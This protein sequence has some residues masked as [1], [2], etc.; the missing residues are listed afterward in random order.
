MIFSGEFGTSFIGSWVSE[1]AIVCYGIHVEEALR[2]ARDP[3]YPLV[4]EAIR[5]GLLVDGAVPESKHPFCFKVYSD[6]GISAVPNGPNG[7][8]RDIFILDE[9]LEGPTGVPGLLTFKSF[10]LR[11][12]DLELKS[13][14]YHSYA[15]LDIEVTPSGEIAVP[16]PVILH[17]YFVKH[18]CEVDEVKFDTIAAFR[19]THESVQRLFNTINPSV[20]PETLVAK[21]VGSMYDTQGTNTASLKVMRQELEYIRASFWTPT[22]DPIA[23]YTRELYNS[24]PEDLKNKE[25]LSDAV[26]ILKKT[27]HVSY[28]W[29]DFMI[30]SNDHLRLKYLRQGPPRP[31]RV[32][33][34]LSWSDLVLRNEH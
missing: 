32:R 21:V 5:G 10:M 7:A 26:D 2:A 14:S 6:D 33:S 25:W 3:R 9:K 28:N 20:V 34:L 16:A 18:K 29:R 17:R 8:F 23:S 1:L 19:P 13:G 12:F 30:P 31:L 24:K 27:T 15:R 4:C 11:K 22:Y